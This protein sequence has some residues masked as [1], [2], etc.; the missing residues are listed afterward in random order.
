M[1]DDL[2]DA[3]ARS[4]RT[5]LQRTRRALLAA[6][7]TAF[8]EKGWLGARVEDIARA[9]G[10]SAAT[11]YN[12]FPTKH[13]LMGNVYGP[14]VRPLVED[15]LGR[16]QGDDVVGV[17]EQ[18]VRDLASVVR[19]NPRLTVAFVDAVQD[20]TIKS[21]GPP[22]G[23]DTNDPRNLAP[24]PLAVTRAIALGQAAGTFR[25]YPPAADLGP[26]VTNLLLL[27]SFT[28]PE[29]TKAETA[30]FTLTVMFG[31]ISPERLVDAGQTGRPFRSSP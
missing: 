8:E 22:R 30:E 11:A 1:A 6:A 5:K 17:L 15:A 21:S 19:E 14:L 20:Y 29:E 3:R 9:A 7:R 26:N 2:S 28:R 23:D 16:L 24:F 13:A 27:R 10:V 4:G 12:H 31:V 18:H 25:A